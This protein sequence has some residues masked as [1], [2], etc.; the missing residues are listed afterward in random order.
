MKIF[1]FFLFA[2]FFKF[3][4]VYSQLPASEGITV[5]QHSEAAFIGKIHTHGWGFGY[6]YATNITARKKD[7]IHTGFFTIRHPKEIKIVNTSILSNSKS[8]VYGKLNYVMC[9]ELAVGRYNILNEKPYWGGIELRH[10]IFLGGTAG[11]IKPSYLYI[12]EF[13]NS[14]PVTTIQ[15]YD[16]EKHFYD[17]IYGRGPFLKGF[18]EIK[19]YPGLNFRTGL[20]FDHAYH[21]ENL[22][23]LEIGIM[24]HAFIKKIPIMAFTDN[25]QVYYLGYISY[26]LGVKK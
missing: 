6:R 2:F 16:P 17:N 19:F 15:K 1:V 5:I 23:A 20:N 21:R 8:Y 22:A 26:Q 11:L 25:Y 9:L 13:S 18:D 12:I 3:Y 24:I 14:F 7:V 10:F 4:L